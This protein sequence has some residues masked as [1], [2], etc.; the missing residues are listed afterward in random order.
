MLWRESF[1]DGF[2]RSIA[3]SA[4]TGL[5]LLVEHIV[6]ETS[7]AEQLARVLSGFDVF[8]IG[9]HASVAELQRREQMRGDRQSGEA[10]EHLKTHEFCRYD[11][12]VDTTKPVAENV[13]AVLRAWS[14]RNL[15]HS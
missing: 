1:F 5:D 7:W 12:E 8:W 10:L 15:D 13:S 11:V 6:E 2:H 14:S 9:V 3:S 4:D